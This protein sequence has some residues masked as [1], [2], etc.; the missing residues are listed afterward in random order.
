M[1]A[2]PRKT[3]NA[4][5]YICFLSN[6]QN[7]DIQAMLSSIETSPFYVALQNM[8]ADGY[9]IMVATENSPIHTRWCVF[10]AH[11]ALKQDISLTVVGFP[12]NLAADRSA[13]VYAFKKERR[14]CQK[15]R[16]LLQEGLCEKLIESLYPGSKEQGGNEKSGSWPWNPEAWRQDDPEEL[17]VSIKRS[18][19]CFLFSIVS[20]ITVIGSGITTMPDS[21]S[22]GAAPLMWLMIGICSLRA[23]CSCYNI[24]L[25]R[26][27]LSLVES[28]ETSGF[29]DVRDAVCSD[30]ED[31]RR[32]HRS[33]AGQEDQIN[34]FLG[35]LVLQ[36]RRPRR[37]E[38]P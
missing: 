28:A 14:L 20:L 21:F 24:S 11:M 10:E 9:M 17:S 7:L 19:C 8:P 38:S 33:I 29:I 26:V 34:S 22:G 18:Q 27:Q 25:F 13:V 32:I 35:R 16:W 3:K 30:D 36:T 5:A 2:W 1:Q 15:K 31:A 12:A 37:R 4:A 6:P 23:M